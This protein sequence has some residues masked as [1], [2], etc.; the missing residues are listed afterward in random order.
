MCRHAVTVSAGR[1]DRGCRPSKASELRQSKEWRETH[2]LRETSLTISTVGEDGVGV[3]GR[4]G[5][6]RALKGLRI[7]KLWAPD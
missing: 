1:S 2:R 7:N 6:G 5:L 3:P 4:G